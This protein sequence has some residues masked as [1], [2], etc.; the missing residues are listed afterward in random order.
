MI[1]NNLIHGDMQKLYFNYFFL[2]LHVTT[3]NV[4]VTCIYEIISC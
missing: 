4:M 1:L 3:N 2:Q